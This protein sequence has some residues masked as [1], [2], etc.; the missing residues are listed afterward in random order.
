MILVWLSPILLFVVLLASGRTTTLAAAVAA[1]LLTA[2]VAVLAG[3]S[4]PGPGG[5]ALHFAAGLWVALPAA[6]VI[7]AG[8]FFAECAAPAAVSTGA[9]D[10]GAL[11]S[12][13]LLFGPFMETATGFGVGYVVALAAVTRLGV[14][15]GPALALAAFSQFL[16]PWGAL[17]VG[18][19]ISTQIAHVPLEAVGWRC[20]VVVAILTG[21]L[22]LLF[23]RIAARGGQGPSP[24]ERLE[25]GAT[26]LAVAVL[27][28]AAN[29]MLPIELAG[30]A[31]L[32]PVLAV[33]HL[34]R[35]GAGSWSRATVL[36]VLPYAGL[37]L[38]LGLTRLV[39]PL[40]Q[41]LHQPHLQP[42]ADA[43]GFS[44]L[45][46]PALPLVL[47]GAWVAA[48]RGGRA[49]VARHLATTARRG[50]RPAILTFLL[51]GMAWIMVR[52]GVSGAIMAEASRLAGPLS[53]GL[54]PL[55]GALGGY[56]TGSNTGAGALSMPLTA[57]LGLGEASTHWVVAAAVVAGSLMTALSPVRMA[58][59]QSL[60]GSAPSV[61][62][63]A[64]VLLVPLA[65]LAITVTLM[66]AL[67]AAGLAG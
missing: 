33:R 14:T 55:A 7:L 53:P 35:H 42:F 6:L 2:G 13:C 10:H 30:I 63:A 52:A 56:L 5:V 18:T 20:A 21:P 54:V 43:A 47:I 58:M 17:G 4:A 49:T 34:W 61:V 40:Q 25:W 39:P 24:A 26:L 11:A 57:R 38:V 1:T 22:L 32:G 51:V 16:V 41:A 31:A 46:S 27:L 45:L 44:P 15:G 19:R 67:L 60:T 36:T 66:I 65:A 8:L 48:A 12:A 23:W 29:S 28:V 3:P 37:V 64:L 50:W 9:R 59:G 62:R